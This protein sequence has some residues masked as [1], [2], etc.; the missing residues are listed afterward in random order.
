MRLSGGKEMK[1]LVVTMGGDQ[2]NIGAEY[3]KRNGN[4]IYAM[5]SDD[6]I[7]GIFELGLFD[8]MHLSERKEQ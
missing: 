4:E 7:V 6:E 2:I 8:E 3:I 1:R 5:N